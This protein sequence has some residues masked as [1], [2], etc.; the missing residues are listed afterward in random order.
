M[1]DACTEELGPG[2][3]GLYVRQ[4]FSVEPPGSRVPYCGSRA[5]SLHSAEFHQR[6]GIPSLSSDNQDV[7]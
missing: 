4:S 7:P 3:P 5:V 1:Y 6:F 2:L